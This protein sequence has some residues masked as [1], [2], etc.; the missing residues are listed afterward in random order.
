M[1]KSIPSEIGQ[2]SHENSPT[3]MIINQNQIFSIRNNASNSL[4][5]LG[6]S[7]TPKDRPKDS[8]FALPIS[9][10]STI[11]SQSSSNTFSWKNEETA[12]ES[13]SA[14]PV[15]PPS[16]AK[17]QLTSSIEDFNKSLDRSCDSFEFDNSE[18]ESAIAAL[19]TVL[20]NYEAPRGWIKKIDKQSQQVYFCSLV[21][22]D[23]VKFY[24]SIFFTFS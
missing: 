17:P 24:Y 8:F 1:S 23:K 10:S 19:Q 3:S 21:S 6:Q 15:V 16:S 13:P 11:S 12:P 20:Q 14:L 4:L 7:A 2:L 5:S 9:H 22:G 18:N